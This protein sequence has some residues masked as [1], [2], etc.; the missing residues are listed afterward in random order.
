MPVE[1]RILKIACEKWN[2]PWR[3]STE[4]LV[5][6]CSIITV[7]PSFYPLVLGQVNGVRKFSFCCHCDNI[8]LHTLLSALWLICRIL[9]IC[10]L[11]SLPDFSVSYSVQEG[12][13]VRR[14][15]AAGERHLEVGLITPS[16]AGT[17]LTLLN[18]WLW[19]LPCG[20]CCWAKCSRLFFRWVWKITTT[21]VC[22]LDDCT[23]QK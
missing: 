11:L 3:E 23:A 4:C 1:Q 13:W 5:F 8:S 15:G 12:M 18:Q 14:C 17:C 16:Q 2:Q 9:P 19:D 22:L 21:K 10:T 6:T 20:K 7:C